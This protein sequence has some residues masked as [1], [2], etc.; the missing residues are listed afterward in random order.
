[1]SAAANTSQEAATPPFDA[2]AIE[3]EC[4]RLSI[5]YARAIDFRAASGTA[6][7]T[8]DKLLPTLRTAAAVPPTLTLFRRPARLRCHFRRSAILADQLPRFDDR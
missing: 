7:C 1:M 5:A 4:A 2:E 3:R 8:K 6:T